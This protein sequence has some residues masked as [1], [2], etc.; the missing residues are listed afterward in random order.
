MSYK[1][2]YDVSRFE[3][4]DIYL[5]KEGTHTKLYDKLGSHLMERQGMNGVYFAVWAPNAERVSVIADF[6]TY[7]DWAHPLK[8]REDGSG[9]WEG[10]I[11]DVREYVTYKYHI[12]SKY[13]NIVNQKTDPYAKYCEKP[14]K[15]ASVTYNIEDYRWQDAQWMEQRTE[16]NGHDKPMSIYEVHLGSWRR[17]V[18]ENNRYLT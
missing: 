16:V 13:H 17:K 1:M 10:F 9:I 2:Y 7:D 11:E 15:S 14:S 8:V 18:E 12:V 6:N 5:F 3:A 4:L